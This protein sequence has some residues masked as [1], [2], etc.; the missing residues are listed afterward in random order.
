LPTE[1]KKRMVE[2][3]MIKPKREIEKYQKKGK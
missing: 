3:K 2:S 1:L